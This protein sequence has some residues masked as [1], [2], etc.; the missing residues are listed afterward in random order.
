M[1]HYLFSKLATK[2]GL[3]QKWL[4]K[5]HCFGDG[6]FWYGVETD[7][8]LN[9]SPPP[10]KALKDPVYEFSCFPF[11]YEMF[12]TKEG[13][14]WLK[15]SMF[16]PN[17]LLYILSAHIYSV[18]VKSCGLACRSGKDTYK[19]IQAHRLTTAYLHRQ[20]LHYIKNRSIKI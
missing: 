5:T 7:L 18:C 16:A 20:Y 15:I 13:L 3:V 17:D 11:M 10:Q 1:S 19:D 8:F 12:P 6:E 9:C 14:N 4:L 2:S